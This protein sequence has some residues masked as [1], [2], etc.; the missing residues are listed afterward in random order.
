MCIGGENYVETEEDYFLGYSETEQ[1]GYDEGYA[2]G[3]AGNNKPEPGER[4]PNGEPTK[5]VT[6]MEEKMV[7]ILD[8]YTDIVWV[9]MK[10][11]ILMDKQ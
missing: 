2:D 9:S 7:V 6:K 8:I 3:R 11:P 10:K 5:R 1:S 4:L